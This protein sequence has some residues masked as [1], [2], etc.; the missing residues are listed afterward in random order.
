MNLFYR[1]L[2]DPGVDTHEHDPLAAVPGGVGGRSPTSSRRGQGSPAYQAVVGADILN[3]PYAKLRRWQPARGPDRAPGGGVP[4]QRN[5]ATAMAP[6]ITADNPG[7]L[8]I[9]EDSTGGYN[10]AKPGGQQ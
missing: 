7:W 1:N 4:A 5:Y 2:P 8:L 3:E 9:F 6:A 10:A